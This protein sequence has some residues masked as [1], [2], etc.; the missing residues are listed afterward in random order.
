MRAFE[1]KDVSCYVDILS[2]S[3]LQNLKG[4]SS[5]ATAAKPVS[6]S[7]KRYLILTYMTNDQKYHYPLSLGVVAKEWG[8]ADLKE[9]YGQLRVELESARA[10]ALNDTAKTD[11]SFSI[12]YDSKKNNRN[13]TKLKEIDQFKSEN[14]ILKAKLARL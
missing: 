10:S 6:K 9:V 3:D 4:K 14:E 12:N 8:V 1:Q 7:N 13:Q 5:G 2:S 11:N